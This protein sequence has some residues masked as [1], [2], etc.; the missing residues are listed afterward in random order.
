LLRRQPDTKIL[1]TSGYTDNAFLPSGK[2]R[3]R[4]ELLRKPYSRE[5]LARKIRQMLEL[6]PTADTPAEPIP[7]SEPAPVAATEVAAPAPEGRIQILVCEDEPLIRMNLVDLLED[8]GHAVAD[9]GN[10]GEALELAANSRFD[11]LITDIGL[12]DMSGLELARRLRGQWPELPVIIAS[13][14]GHGD[15]P[16]L[17]GPIG[18][19]EKPFT[20]QMLRK[21]L[22]AFTAAR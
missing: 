18:Y 3:Q 8:M 15:A 12:P 10:A 22:A 7:A 1:Y 4:G 21:A 9:A 17:E 14:R 16:P 13:G 20:M 19:L 5:S 2:P 11:I 6:A